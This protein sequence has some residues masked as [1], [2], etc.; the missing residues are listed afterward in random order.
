MKDLSDLLIFR[1]DEIIERS[2]QE[3]FEKMESIESGNPRLDRATNSM[4]RH[5]F[6]AG[7]LACLRAILESENRKDGIT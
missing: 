3:H 4:A 2:W 7:W 1:T 5:V 6:W